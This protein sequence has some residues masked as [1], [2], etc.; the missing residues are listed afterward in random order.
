MNFKNVFLI[1]SLFP[2]LCFAGVKDELEKECMTSTQSGIPAMQRGYTLSFK[3]NAEF[4]AARVDFCE[5]GAKKWQAYSS[6]IIDTQNAEMKLAQDQRAKQEDERKRQELEAQQKQ[7][8]QAKAVED[9]YQ[10]NATFM[11]NEL[12]KGGSTFVECLERSGVARKMTQGKNDVKKYPTAGFPT[13]AWLRMEF[14]PLGKDRGKPDENALV[15]CLNAMKYGVNMKLE[16]GYGS[17]FVYFTHD[18]PE[19]QSAN[20]S[21]P[22]ATKQSFKPE[23]QLVLTELKDKTNVR[24]APE[25]GAAVVSQLQPGEKVEIE[26]QQG[27]EWY[28]VRDLK[29]KSVLGYISEKRII[30]NGH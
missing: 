13:T 3:T 19:G 9:A 30:F 12:S 28:K 18:A 26:T 27:S 20:K 24:S 4:Q 10:R 21:T 7:Q 22:T 29:T 23:W 6:K 25:S 17:T 15:G 1:A 14:V 16:R 2:L 5:N 8:Q 11:R